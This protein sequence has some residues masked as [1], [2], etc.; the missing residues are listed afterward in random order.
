MRFVHRQLA[1]ARRA[2]SPL[3]CGSYRRAP[4]RRCRYTFGAALS[5]HFG[6]NTVH[7]RGP[8]TRPYKMAAAQPHSHELEAQTLNVFISRALK[9]VLKEAPKKSVQLRQACV[10]VIGEG[11]QRPPKMGRRTCL[12]TKLTSGLGLATACR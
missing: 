7:K 6:M 12:A 1:L 4:L 2:Q 3:P 11:V 9:Q 10:A 5:L 8:P